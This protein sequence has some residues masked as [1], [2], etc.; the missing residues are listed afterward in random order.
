MTSETYSLRFSMTD[1]HESVVTRVKDDDG[2]VDFHGF[3]PSLHE[4]LPLSSSSN[5]DVFFFMSSLEYLCTQAALSSVVFRFL[6]LKGG[7]CEKKEARLGVVRD[8]P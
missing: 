8:L 6:T 3:C 7:G 1:T 4:W 2:C 5:F